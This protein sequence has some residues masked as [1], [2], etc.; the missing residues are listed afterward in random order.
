M[1]KNQDYR[2]AEEGWGEQ[3]EREGVNKLPERDSESDGVVGRERLHPH[4][5]IGRDTDRA[6]GDYY[7][8]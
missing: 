6:P 2:W 4:H 5:R 7:D 8:D 1:R 3:M